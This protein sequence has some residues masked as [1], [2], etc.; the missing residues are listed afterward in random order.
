MSNLAIK[1][2]DVQ[3]E[4]ISLNWQENP[5]SK[6]LLDVLVQILKDKYLQIAKENQEIFKE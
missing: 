3:E 4:K 1:I 5:A 2:S 6:V